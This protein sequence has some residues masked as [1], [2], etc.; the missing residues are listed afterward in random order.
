[1][2]I[3]ILIFS[4]L[5]NMS[6]SL[7]LYRLRDYS[8]AI[9]VGTLKGVQAETLRILVG[10]HSTPKLISKAKNSFQVWVL[11]FLSFGYATAEFE[12]TP[13]RL[14]VYRPEEHMY[15]D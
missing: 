7:V 12:V 5:S 3:G 15:V 4:A 9:D 8:Q 2:E 10:K 11:S 13:E 1:M 14:G 6:S